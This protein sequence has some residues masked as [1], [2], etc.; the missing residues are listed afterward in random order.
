MELVLAACVVLF[1]TS[2][3]SLTF[4]YPHGMVWGVQV[5]VC[6]GQGLDTGR[7]TGAGGE[8]AGGVWIS[9]VSWLEL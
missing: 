9:C 6:S 7:T 5:Q 2:G 4:H 8:S 1:S 3:Q